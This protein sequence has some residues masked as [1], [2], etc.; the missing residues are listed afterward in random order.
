MENAGIDIQQWLDADPEIEFE[1]EDTSELCAQTLSDSIKQLTQESEGIL[2]IF[3]DHL[4]SA[5]GKALL[6]SESINCPDGK[7][8]SAEQLA[9][10]FR[11]CFASFKDWLGQL[12][13]ELESLKKEYDTVVKASLGP[14]GEALA[15]QAD[16]IQAQLKVAEVQKRGVAFVRRFQEMLKK[17]ER[18]QKK[19][20][21]GGK[22]LQNHIKLLPV[23]SYD[24]IRRDTQ[25]LI[26][27]CDAIINRGKTDIAAKDHHQDTETEMIPMKLHFAPKNLTTWFAIGSE[28]SCCVGFEEA[29]DYLLDIGVRLPVAENL[30]NHTC[31]YVSFYWPGKSFQY[32]SDPIPPHLVS[33][34]IEGHPVVASAHK[35]TMRKHFFTF[36]QRFGD[37]V[38]LPHCCLGTRN[39]D[40]PE[41]GL[42]LLQLPPEP[43]AEG[44]GQ[45]IRFH[46]IG[47][48]VN[49]KNYKENEIPSSNSSKPHVFLE[50]RDRLVFGLTDSL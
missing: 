5:P 50:A 19:A 12:T 28:S 39:N 21:E 8:S 49:Q 17:M 23:D 10:Q 44:Q 6:S 40:I 13:T 35:E 15:N 1:I 33:D 26:S 30:K 45:H 24:E 32:R 25:R 2:K 29:L 7:T 47:G 43:K 37:K 9:R 42:E 22:I 18:R 4:R 3:R 16:D 36:A 46:K 41:D 31:P 14:D 11:H 20:L 38:N 27:S 48:D 34:N